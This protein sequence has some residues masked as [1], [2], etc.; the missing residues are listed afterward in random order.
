MSSNRKL[1]YRWLGPFRVS[2]ADQVKGTYLLEELDGTRMRGTYAG[3]RLKKF[4]LRQGQFE[5]AE[6]DLLSKEPY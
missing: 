2:Q 3:S 6:A 4:I 5:P 1:S